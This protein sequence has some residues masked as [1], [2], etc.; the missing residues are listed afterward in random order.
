MKHL[1]ILLLILVLALSRLTAQTAVSGTVT[2]GSEPLAGANVFILGTVEGS[3]T[4]SLGHFS[5]TTAQSGSV[6][7]RATFV[8][9]EDYSLTAD[10]TQLQQ[11]S[12]SLQERAATIDEVCVS[13][14]TY[15]FGKSDN[16]KTMDAL[17]VVLS[18]NSCGDI[19][20]ALQTLPGTQMVGEDGK[21]Y[22]RG[23]ESSECQTF[24]NGMHVLVPYST[25]TE[26]T[27]VRG[28]FSP[29]LFK[30]INFSLG[31]YSG[32]YGQALSAVLPMETTDRATSDKYGVSAS[33]VD[34]NIGGTQVG[35]H[36]SLSFN[37]A[38]TDLSLYDQL[39]PQRYEFH[40]PY[41]LLAA[42][43]QYKH[44]FSAS[45][46]LK[47]YVG[48]DWTTVGQRLEGRD[49]SLTE[50]NGYANL[51]HRTTFAHGITLFTGLAHSVVVRDIDQALTPGDPLEVRV[52]PSLQ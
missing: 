35:T 43:G 40:Q 21:L 25:Q 13:A 34:W 39:F 52:S 50:K 4:D 11:L 3:L 48:A 19:V 20:A 6:T 41:R 5:F 36:N 14:S 33:L 17:D 2:V 51:T 44:E 18:G 29:F 31:G 22:V 24:V 46:V 16:F 37:A 45:S 27:A 28:R 49:L 23:G 10:V 38:L 1:A 26:N 30:G 8:G 32:E 7:L 47:S 15:S 12:V 9:F 42:E